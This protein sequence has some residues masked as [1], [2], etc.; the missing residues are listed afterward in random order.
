MNIII[1]IDGHAGC[2]KSTTA[3]RVAQQLNYVYI[4]SGAMYRAVTHY[5]IHHQVN[6]DN[7]A[8]VQKALRNIHISF[9]LNPEGKQE[10]YVNNLNV[11]AQIRTLQ[12]SDKVSD[13]STIAEV[14]KF[15]VAQ[16]QAMGTEKGIV[17]DG[18]DIGTVVFPKAEL[19]VFMTADM[20]TRALRRQEELAQKGEQIDLDTIIENLRTRDYLDSTRKEGPLKKAKDA[21][22]INTTDLS[23]EQQ[24]EKVVELAKQRIGV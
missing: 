4:D 21:I 11:E 12:V 15:L 2:G 19:K 17:M 3:K 22:V 14:R 24:V 8:E 6:W 9:K 18:R 1:A 7:T 23:I 13:V 10:T 5:F 20:N 16:Q